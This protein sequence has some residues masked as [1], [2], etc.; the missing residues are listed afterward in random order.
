LQMTFK[1]TFHRGKQD[2]AE[3]AKRIG[4][5][6]DR[7]EKLLEPF[8][9]KQDKVDTLVGR[10]FLNEPNKRGYLMEY[11]SRRNRLIK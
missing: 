1:N 7:L 10:S 9:L 6:D 8:L 4:V 5:R 11:G 3:F 2:F